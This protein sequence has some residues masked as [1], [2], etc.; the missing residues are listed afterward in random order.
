[1]NER[2]LALCMQDNEDQITGIFPPQGQTE[3]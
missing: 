2:V 3:V 1:M